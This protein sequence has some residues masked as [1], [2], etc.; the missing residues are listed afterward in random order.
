MNLMFLDS[1]AGVVAQ[2]SDQ[3]HHIH[4]SSRCGLHHLIAATWQ[5]M[6]SQRVSLGEMISSGHVSHQIEI[7]CERVH[8]YTS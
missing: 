5:M 2:A 6:S 4:V 8:H 3:L 1:T 7:E